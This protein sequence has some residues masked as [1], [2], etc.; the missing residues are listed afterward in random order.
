[1]KMIPETMNWLRL[2]RFA[3]PGD[4][5]MIYGHQT[6]EISLYAYRFPEESG[7]ILIGSSNC[8]PF[9]YEVYIAVELLYTV[10]H[11]STTKMFP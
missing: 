9:C 8:P 7:A 5:A 10:I 6:N 11:S 2:N 3:R 1:M 4:F